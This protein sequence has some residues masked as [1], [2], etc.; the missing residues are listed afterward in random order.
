MRPVRQSEPVR[1]RNWV[2]PADSTSGTL[3][4]RFRIC[5]TTAITRSGVGYFD[6]DRRTSQSEKILWTQA[7]IH[8]LEFEKAAHQQAG[9]DQQDEG[10]GDLTHQERFAQPLP[11]KSL[12]QTASRLLQ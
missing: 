3:S 9:S 2:A 5:R 6:S 10:Q 11:L 4:I 8:L 1:G 7:Q 12:I